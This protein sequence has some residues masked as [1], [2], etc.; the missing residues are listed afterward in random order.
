MRFDRL[1]PNILSSN[2]LWWHE[3]SLMDFAGACGWLAVVAGVAS[4]SMEAV[5]CS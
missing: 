3:I 2:E 4:I 5:L 1:L